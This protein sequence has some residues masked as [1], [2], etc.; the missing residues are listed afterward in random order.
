M[1]FDVSPDLKAAEAKT[2]RLSVP[3][4]ELALYNQEMKKVVEPGE[5]ELQIGASSD[6]IKMIKKMNVLE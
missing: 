4:D 3:V 5:F 1:H 6:Q 2:V